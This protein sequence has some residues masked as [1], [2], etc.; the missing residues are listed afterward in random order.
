MKT[1]WQKTFS[2]LCTVFMLSVPM[3]GLVAQE[4]GAADSSFVKAGSSGPPKTFLSRVYPN[5]FRFSASFRLELKKAAH[6]SL[7]L[8]DIRGR[9]VQTIQRG[10]V[11]PGSSTFTVQ[12]GN[13]PTGTYFL[14]MQMR[15]AHGIIITERS[16]LLI[17]H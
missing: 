12:R 8:Y 16:K 5:P 3:A 10:T 15:Q 13:L 2:I 7:L 1:K 14:V 4:E 17:L 6:V 11:Q 9:L